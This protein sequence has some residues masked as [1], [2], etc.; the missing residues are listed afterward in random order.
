MDMQMQKEEAQS[1]QQP[2]G[3]SKLVADIHSQLLQLN[4]MVSAKFPEEGK[5]L[6]SIIQQ[7]QG[8]IDGLGQAPGAKKPEMPQPGTTTEQAQGRPVQQVY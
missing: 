2:G 5:E 8:F 3:A 4:D 6:Q 1:Q 7:Y